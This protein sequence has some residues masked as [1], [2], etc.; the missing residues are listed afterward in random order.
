MSVRKERKMIKDLDEATRLLK[1]TQLMLLGKDNQPISDLYY[2]LQIAL[3]IMEES[4]WISV[5]ERLP[6]TAFG[7][8]VTVYE[9]DRRTGE[10]FEA[11]L[12]YAVGYDGETWNDIDGEVI[13]F[14]VIAWRPLPEPYKENEGE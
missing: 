7:C 1:A 4:R 12:P 9:T 6:E 11:I 10:E 3:D 5:N 8:L 13:P 14:E 2:A